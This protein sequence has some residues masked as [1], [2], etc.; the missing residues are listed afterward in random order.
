[1]R[2]RSTSFPNSLRRRSNGDILL[3]DRMNDRSWPKPKAVVRLIFSGVAFAPTY[4][5]SQHR[6]FETV[7]SSLAVFN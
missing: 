3:H 4:Q 1:M 2:L 6:V 5:T 7:N